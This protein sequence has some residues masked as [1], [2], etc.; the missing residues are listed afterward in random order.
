VIFD[1]QKQLSLSALG[2]DVIS[3]HFGN[4][5]HEGFFADQANQAWRV[6]MNHHRF[7]MRR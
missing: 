2:H 4:H 1:D 7:A 6:E 3:I 5:G